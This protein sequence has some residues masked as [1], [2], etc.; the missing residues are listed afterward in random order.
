VV[1]VSLPQNP[2]TP[3]VESVNLELNIDSFIPSTGNVGC[4]IAT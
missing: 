3:K 1:A 2:K 4:R